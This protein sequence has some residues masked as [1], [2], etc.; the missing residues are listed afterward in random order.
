M[1]NKTGRRKLA[2]DRYYTGTQTFPELKVF[3]R[4]PA[5]VVEGVVGQR[6]HHHLFPQR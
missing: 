5:A 1:G 6:D 2:Q 3:S 4:C